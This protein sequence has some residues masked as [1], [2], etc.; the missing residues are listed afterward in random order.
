[1]K[2][3]HETFMQK[4]IEQA[5]AAQKIDEV[6]VGAVIVDAGGQM[7]AQDHNRT[8]SNCDPS[9]HAEVNVLRAAA[10]QLKNYR[11]S[12]T[13][14]YVTVEPCVMCMGAIVHARVKTVVFGTIDPKWGAAGTLYQIA[15]DPRL[16]HQVEIVSGI[17]AQACRSVIQ[18]FF[19]RR[20]ARA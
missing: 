3:Q 9:A 17:C 5:I 13:T 11:L 1:M 16:N 4:A 10:R 19:R 20:R 2:M 18:D 7:I 8:I 6:P 12:S 14:L 15:Q